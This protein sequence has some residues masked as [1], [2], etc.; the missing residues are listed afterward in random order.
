MKQ[1]SIFLKKECVESWRNYKWIWM[2]LVFLLLGLT[3]PITTYYLPEIIQSG[4]NLPEGA[5]I[6]LPTPSAS[7]VL[8]GTI[9][10]QFNVIGILVVVLAF[11]ASIPGEKKSG[12]ASLILV[13][14]VSFIAYIL[15]KWTSAMLVVWVSYF[16][17]MLANWYYTYQLFEKVDVSLAVKA[18]FFYGIW[19]TFVV[20]LVFFFG[21]IVKSSGLNAF[22][23]LAST[24]ILSTGA[25]FFANKLLWLPSLLTKYTGE[26]L[27]TKAIPE[28]LYGASIITI[29]LIGLFLASGVFIF[30]RKELV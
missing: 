28:G 13:K 8:F 14:P 29:L 18:F 16:L 24:I 15:A 7:E 1:F 22:L 17:G 25:S 9:D 19:L 4:G 6:K 23:T 11:M 12:S 2:P 26:L 27:K 5:V 21:S 3:Q 30:K 10:S 20:T